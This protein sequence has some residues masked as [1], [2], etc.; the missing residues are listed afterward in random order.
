M[1]IKVSRLMGLDREA[2]RLRRISHRVALIRCDAVVDDEVKGEGV[3]GI[4]GPHSAGEV[5]QTIRTHPQ[6]HKFHVR[7]RDSLP[8]HNSLLCAQS[9]CWR[10]QQL[11]VCPHCR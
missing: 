1:L 8:G 10:L 5:R 9:D 4:I 11:A 2:D 6:V 7:E 3:L